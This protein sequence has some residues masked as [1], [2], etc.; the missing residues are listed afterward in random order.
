MIYL[1]QCPNCKTLK[2]SQFDYECCI[3]CNGWDMDKVMV[4]TE[5]NLL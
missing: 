4:V 5:D 3:E 2:I 1:Y